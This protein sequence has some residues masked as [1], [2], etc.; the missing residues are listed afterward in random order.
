M[1][2]VAV[3]RKLVAMTVV[4]L[5]GLG[6]LA[7]T[8]AA[9]AVGAAGRAPTGDAFYVPPQPLA[10]AKPGTIIR[11]TPI[12]GAP[13]GARA[14]KILYHSRAV[15]GQDIAVSGVVIA[16]T[17]SRTARRT[18][19]GHMGARHLGNGRRVRTLEA[20]RHR[21]R[22]RVHVGTLPGMALRCRYVQ[23]FLDAGYVV[24]ATDYEGI[25]TP[26][27]HPFLVGESEGRSVL[28][29]ARAATRPEGAPPPRARCSSSGT[30]KAATRRCSPVSSRRRTHRSSRV[31]GVA[32]EAPGCP[33]SNTPC[34]SSASAT[35]ANGFVVIGRRSLPRRVPTVR[36]RGAPH[37]RCARAGL[38]RRPEMPRATSATTFSSCPT[39]CSHTTRSTSLRSQTIVHSELLR[40]PSDRRAV[41]RR[42]GNRR[43]SCPTIPHRR[44]RDEGLRGG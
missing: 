16:P 38:D 14:W 13:A 9:P 2:I 22:A 17:G 34:R 28:D 33:T 11:S 25:G 23:T 24:A 18:G 42:P 21:V 4:V 1:T 8:S 5:S 12:A 3:Y 7:A 35:F 36:P 29:A 19:G 30:R 20:I 44:V 31:L 43:S 26:G 10:K 40:Q 6:V 15:D 32:A 27:L 37:P 41:A 39:S